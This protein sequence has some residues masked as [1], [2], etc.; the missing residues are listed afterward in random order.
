MPTINIP[1]PTSVRITN[2][3]S[4]IS[5]TIGLVLIIAGLA[6]FA[7]LIWGGIAWITSG[8]DKSQVEAAQKR[9]QAAIV[10]L[11]IVF[12]AWALMLLI[13]GFFGVTILGNIS[14]PT[15]F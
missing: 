6:A 8:G 2:I 7:F 3:G 10:G 5:S 1:Q 11:F 9:I 14:L 4:L 15:P 13:Q 12:A